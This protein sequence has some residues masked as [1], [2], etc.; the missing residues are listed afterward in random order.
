DLQPDDRRPGRRPFVHRPALDRDGPLGRDRAARRLVRDRRLLRNRMAGG[1]LRR[2]RQRRGLRRRRD[3]GVSLAADLD[4]PPR[5]ADGRRG[6]GGRALESVEMSATTKADWAEQART[7]LSG[8]GYR[9]GG[10]R[11]AV[12]DALSEQDCA[13]TALELEEKVRRRDEGGGRAR[14][15]R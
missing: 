9:R 1:V 15:H 4:R 10:A 11:A 6:R 2:H 13:I 12:I 5:W 7:A 8:A 14:L 3:L